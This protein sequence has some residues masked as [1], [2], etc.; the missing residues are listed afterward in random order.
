MSEVVSG[1]GVNEVV[2]SACIW[3]SNPSCTYLR[4]L[5]GHYSVCVERSQ[6]T[7]PRVALNTLLWG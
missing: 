3:E 5:T 1:V 2:V 7:D 6:S 4:D